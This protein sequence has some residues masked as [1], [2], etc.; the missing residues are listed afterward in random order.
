MA[1]QV[2]VSREICAPAE[3]V[4]A[5]ITDLPRMGEWS[6][7]NDGATWMSGAQG[8]SVGAAFKGSNKNG[9]KKWTTDGK[10]VECESPRVFAFSVSVPGFKVA[11]WRYEIEPTAAGCVVSE[12]W[13]DRRNWVA[14]KVGGLVSGINDRS[15]HNR[16]TMDETLDRLK[17]AAEER[18][19]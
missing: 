2:K 6:P 1:D 4:W 5:M 15:S 14:K 12:S 18:P 17:S 8:P 16:E 3:K 19:G 13:T 9:T 7:E 10:V 11:D